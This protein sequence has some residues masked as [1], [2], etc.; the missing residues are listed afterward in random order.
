MHYVDKSVDIKFISCP[1]WYL[2]G[3]NTSEQPGN[4]SKRLLECYWQQYEIK[5]H[6]EGTTSVH[7]HDKKRELE[8]DLHA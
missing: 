1:K 8:F 2:P 3:E 4:N 7:E 5:C 6:D